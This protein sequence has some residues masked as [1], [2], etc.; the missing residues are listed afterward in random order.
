MFGSDECINSNF[1]AEVENDGAIFGLIEY[2]FKIKKDRCLI[3]LDYQKL[4]PS[5]WTVDICREPIH[6]K[7]H[8]YFSS[9]VYLKEGYCMEQ[10]KDAFCV[11]TRELSKIIDGEGLVF[12]EGERDTLK[13]SHGKI[14]CAHLLLQKHLV[15][16]KIFAINAPNNPKL[17]RSEENNGGSLATPPS[18]VQKSQIQKEEQPVSKPID[19][20]D[21]ENLEQF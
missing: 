18:P 8:Q 3:H 16:G 7:N 6:L 1:E 17:F 19:L 21:R 15:E 13:T 20:V 4:F 14:F 5:Q 11:K 9:K 2:K 12:A 10:S